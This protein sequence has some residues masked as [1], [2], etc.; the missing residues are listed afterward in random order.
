MKLTKP[1]T[2]SV[3]VAISPLIKRP[4]CV[5]HNS[6]PRSA[7]LRMYGTVPQLYVYIHG[8]VFKRRDNISSFTYWLTGL[9]GT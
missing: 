6:L 9:E 4:G 7:E 3:P 1:P 5:A 8:V 2:Q